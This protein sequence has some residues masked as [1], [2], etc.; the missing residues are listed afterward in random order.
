V[1][2]RGPPVSCATAPSMSFPNQMELQK[3]SFCF[4]TSLRVQTKSS[5]F[6]LYQCSPSPGPSVGH[7]AEPHMSTGT[8]VG[9]QTVSETLGQA[10]AV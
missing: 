5:S 3:D 8:P 7:V 2:G 6:K 4:Y 9:S 1:L 10:S